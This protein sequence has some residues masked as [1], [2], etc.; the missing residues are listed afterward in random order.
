MGARAS[1]LEYVG[2]V[3]VALAVPPVGVVWLGWSPWVFTAFLV[4]PLVW[5]PLS[6]VWSHRD[7]SEL[8]PSLGQTA[9]VVA[10]Y[11]IVLA[12]SMVWGSRP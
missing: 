6:T 12:A 1:K 3:L 11:G 9:R 2:L 10:L 8:I 5:R 4:L 7:A